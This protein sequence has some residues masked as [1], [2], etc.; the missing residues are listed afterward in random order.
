MIYWTYEQI[1]S[2]IFGLDLFRN[3]LPGFPDAG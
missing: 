2:A 3:L 1:L